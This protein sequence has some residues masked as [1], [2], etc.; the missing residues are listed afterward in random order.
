M[1]LKEF[2]TAS[3][4][5]LSGLYPAEEA[6]SITGVL[7]REYL[8]VESYT[9]L[10]DPSHQLKDKDVWKAQAALERLACGEPLQYVLG[11]AEFYGRRFKVGPA[12]LVPRPETEELCRIA[13]DAAAMVQRSRSAFGSKA[14]PVRILDLCTGSGCIAW[15]LAANVPGAQVVGLDISSEALEVARSQ[16]IVEAGMIAPHFVQADIFDDGAVLS[17]LEGQAPFDMILSNPPYVLE[18]E[19]ASMRR[20]V[21]DYEPALALFVPDDDFGLFYRKISFWAEKLLKTDSVGFV[22]I[23]E[24]FGDG[25]RGIFES[26][27]FRQTKVIRDI[28]GRD[29]IVQFRK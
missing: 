5:R 13:T 11:Y 27:G 12:V 16:H 22:E 18:K 28:S 15:T 25:V 2:V 6:A 9:F 21:L 7:C 26:D 20:N 17:A 14:T 8:G 4:S 3:R 29:R 24:A 19:R 10:V 1:L 23:N